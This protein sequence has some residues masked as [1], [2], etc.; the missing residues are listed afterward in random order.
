MFL[1]RRFDFEQC[2]QESEGNRLYRF[3]STHIGIEVGDA[4]EIRSSLA[5]PA[6]VNEIAVADTQLAR[7]S[8]LRD[9]M[10]HHDEP[11]KTGDARHLMFGQ[12]I[13]GA[14]SFHLAILMR[15]M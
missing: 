13:G 8:D 9:L 7:R 15:T 10:R 14:V 6:F 5:S 1:R 4:R 2:R 12:Q 11:V 3:N